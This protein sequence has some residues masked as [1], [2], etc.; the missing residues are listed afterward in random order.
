MHILFY[1]DT[2]IGKMGPQNQGCKSELSIQ[3]EN[4]YNIEKSIV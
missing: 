3:T 2:Q 1:K 4:M